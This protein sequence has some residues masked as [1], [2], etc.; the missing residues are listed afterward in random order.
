MTFVSLDPVPIDVVLRQD[1]V[2]LLPVPTLV[3][4]ALTVFCEIATHEIPGLE[5]QVR[6]AQSHGPQ[7]IHAMPYM[8]PV[9]GIGQDDVCSK[10]LDAMNL[11]VENQLWLRE[12]IICEYLVKHRC[13]VQFL[14]VD[15]SNPSFSVR[16]KIVPLLVALREGGIVS[17]TLLNT[18]SYRR[19]I[20]D[21]QPTWKSCRTVRCGSD[22]LLLSVDKGHKLHGQTHADDAEHRQ[23]QSHKIWTGSFA[24]GCR[25]ERARL[26]YLTYLD[27][28]NARYII[29]AGPARRYDNS[30]GRI[31]MHSVKERKEQKKCLRLPRTTPVTPTGM[32]LKHLPSRKLSLLRPPCRPSITTQG[33]LASSL[34]LFSV[35][36]PSSSFSNLHTSFGSPHTPTPVISRPCKRRLVSCGSASHL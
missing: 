8:S 28:Y 19:I 24:H 6:F 11:T 12:E 17:D 4:R 13:I 31:W 3:N 10:E 33:R 27:Q 25:I 30:D 14:I 21:I 22:V 35:L 15:S 5:C 20:L 23:P 34:Y 7:I 1:L 2:D 32:G 18:H 36:Y 26:A 9:R 16:S 29:L